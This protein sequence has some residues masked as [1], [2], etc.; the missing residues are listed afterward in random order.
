VRLL[1][2]YEHLQFV[3]KEKKFFFCVCESTVCH[4]Y[5]CFGCVAFPFVL[6][7]RSVEKR[8]SYIHTGGGVYEMCLY[9]LFINVAFMLCV[10][11]F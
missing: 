7:K 5:A 2:R 4:F 3:V 1:Y 11:Q 8:E 6:Q 9:V 10:S